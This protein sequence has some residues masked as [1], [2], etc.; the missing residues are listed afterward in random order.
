MKRSKKLFAIVIFFFFFLILPSKTWA[1][2]I[3]DP[4]KTYY[5]DQ[6]NLIDKDTKSYLTR[7]NKELEQKTG[8][9]VL[10]VSLANV[11]N[12]PLETGT[13]I[14]RKWKVGDKDK[15]NGVLIF[16]S[17]HVG[18]EKKDISIITGYGIEGRLN[19]G[20]V[21]RIIDTY[22]LDYMRKGNFSKGVKEG[23]NAI[24][25]EIAAEYQV[26]MDGD[27]EEYSENLEDEEGFDLGS[28]FIMF[29]MFII[30]SQF[31]AGNTIYRGGGFGSFGGFSGG[32]FFGDSSSGGFSGGFS[33]GGGSSGGG[34]A[35]RGI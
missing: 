2:E 4:P 7:V 21:G 10:F 18:R 33:G 15:E 3:P 1:D 14:F 35:S 29:I 17:Q 8:S 9:Q 6:L 13:S 34:G 27:F 28:L 31:F 11:E 12:D 32:G 26:Q 22:M 19:D 5:L 25:G 23:F 20:K 30:L 16:I 24:V